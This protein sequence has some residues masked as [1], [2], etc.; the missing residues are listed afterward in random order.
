MQPPA[1]LGEGDE[2]G[3]DI[4]ARGPHGEKTAADAHE[5]ETQLGHHRQC[6]ER[7]RRG[8]VVRLP[9]PRL[10]SRQLGAVGDDL[11]AAQAEPRRELDQ[12]RGLPMARLQQRHLKLRTGE[13]EGEAGQSTSAADVDKRAG[14][15]KQ[16][17]QDERILD[18]RRVGAA[19]RPRPIPEQ[20][21]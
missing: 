14:L 2:G 1:H 12:E 4:I 3:V 20:L 9:M 15:A 6:R 7:S 13:L 10:V 11:D 21:K 8:E 5:W 16:R 18:E 19:E 17:Q